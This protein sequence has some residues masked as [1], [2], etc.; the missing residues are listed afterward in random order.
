MSKK[1]RVSIETKGQGEPEL[2]ASSHQEKRS[3]EKSEGDGR[4][5]RYV[6]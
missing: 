4:T 2:A 5:C 6:K 3:L 1:N